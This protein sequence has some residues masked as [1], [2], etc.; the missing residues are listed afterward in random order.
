MF[1]RFGRPH[2]QTL[3]DVI[4]NPRRE[5]HN[6]RRQAEYEARER[7][8]KEHLRRAAG[9]KRVE[10][11]ARRLVCV[12]CGTRC[13]DERWNAIAPSGWDAPRETHP[14]LCDDD[15]ARHHR[16]TPSPTS[17]PRS[18]GTWLSRFRA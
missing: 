10:R 17:P 5:A 13:A 18:P 15:S 2:N 9:Q 3:L 11:E 6:A 16:R 14:H 4:G 1:R 12:H 7:A 8:Y